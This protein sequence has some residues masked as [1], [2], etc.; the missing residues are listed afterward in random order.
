M[1]ATRTSFPCD[2]IELDTADQKMASAMGKIVFMTL[3]VWTAAGGSGGP[4][5]E[6]TMARYIVYSLPFTLGLA[7]CSIYDSARMRTDPRAVLGLTVYCLCAMTSMA[8][9]S[10]F[11][12]DAIRDVAIISGYLLLFVF[13]FRAPGSSVDIALFTLGV[14]LLVEASMRLN[15]NLQLLSTDGIYG[16]L[17]L[18]TISEGAGILGSHGILES[19]L[20]FPLGVI[21]LYHVSARN[22]GRALITGALMFVAFKRITFVGVALAIGCDMALA[23]ARSLTTRKVVAV[24][25]VVGL[26]ITALLSTQLFRDAYNDLAVADSSANGISLG[27]YEIAQLLR[28]Q[29]KAGQPSNWLVGFGPG[30][31]DAQVGAHFMLSNPHND[32]LKILYDYGYLGFAAIHVVMFLTLA[33]HR[34]GLMIYLYSATVMITDNVFIYLFYQTFIAL[35][36]YAARGRNALPLMN[37]HS[38]RT[39]ASRGLA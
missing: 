26:S 13:W 5:S 4:D 16:F 30:A 21:L 36:M 2:R 10:W 12:F 9:N 33:R 27:R 25:I 29:F 6:P 15:F 18:S 22:W 11:N 37:A 34:L 39:D 32:W 20:G 14:C 35:V 24:L 1:T 19:T 17:G 3:V 7:Y 31:A 23:Q 28:D 8:A 38:V